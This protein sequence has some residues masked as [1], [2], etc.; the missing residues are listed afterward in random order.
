MVV[1]FNKTD[2]IAVGIVL[3]D[4]TYRGHGIGKLALR[5]YLEYFKNLGYTE[6]YTQ[7]WS[8]NLPMIG[9]ATSLGFKEIN[10]YKDLRTVNGKKYDGLTFEL[11]I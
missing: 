11:K 2:K 3:P 5:K 4:T 10:R 9:L 8:G 6:I 1:D 7:T